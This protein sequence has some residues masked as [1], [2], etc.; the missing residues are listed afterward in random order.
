MDFANGQ[1]VLFQVEVAH[2][3]LH[4]RFV[5]K[6][7]KAGTRCGAA[8]SLQ[9]SGEDDPLRRVY[10]GKGLLLFRRT[11]DR[12][13][14]EPRASRRQS[15]KVLAIDIGGNS[16]KVLVPVTGETEP[17][18]FPSGPTLTPR[19]MVSAVL[20]LTE[21]WQ[22]RRGVDWISRPGPWQPGGFR[23]DQPRHR[24]VHFDFPK[25]FGHPV[26]VINDAAMQALGSYQGG[27]MLFLG[28]GT[29]LGSALIV[30]GNLMPMEL[31]QLPYKDGTYES[32]L[33]LN[34]L[35]APRHHEVARIRPP[36][37]RQIHVGSRTR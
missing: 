2:R 19:Q 3:I 36:G 13:E 35:T 10:S 22:L 17:R 27:K 21:D 30:D 5:P 24:W 15:M 29:G 18:K 1:L 11:S 26:K 12:M 37:R 23:A 16:V 7:R 4:C 9:E 31:G 8:S 6:R 25:A 32:Y 34:G 14:F 20:K 33:G 28:L